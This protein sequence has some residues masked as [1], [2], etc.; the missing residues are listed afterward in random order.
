MQLV[1]LGSLCIAAKYEEIYAPELRDYYYVSANTY[2]KERIIKMEYDILSTLNFDVLY[3]SP[4]IF[5]RRYH[6]IT[7]SAFKSLFLAQFILEFSL[8]EYFMLNY[9]SSIKAASCLYIAR[10][11]LQYEEIWTKELEICTGYKDNDLEDAILNY[12]KLINLIPV[13]TLNSTKKKFSDKKY[14][15]ISKEYCSK[16]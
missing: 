5:L 16:C 14:F 3:V 8:M 13:I 12:N 10:K 4:L 1:A 11:L 7:Q 2:T 9:S 6:Q 15:E